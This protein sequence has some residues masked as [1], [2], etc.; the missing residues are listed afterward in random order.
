VSELRAARRRLHRKTLVIGALLAGSY[1]SLVISDFGLLLRVAAAAVLVIALVAV[2][3]SVMHDANHGAYSNHRWVNRVM[4]YTSDLLGASSWLWR[5]QHNNLHHGNTNVVGF[6][7][8]VELAPFARLAP[9]QPW[10]RWFRW[11][12]IYIWPLYGFL[13]MKNLLIADTFA[14]IQRKM[15]DQPLRRPVRAHV[16]A[17]VVLGKAAHLSW[18]VV[19]PLLFNPWWKVLVFYLACSWCVGF[20]LALIFQLAHC[21]D[22]ADVADPEAAR[23]GDDFAM[24]QL[25]TTVDISSPMPVFGHLF[26]WVV[27]GLDHQIEHHLAPRLPHTVYPKV[28][29][30][31]RAACEEQGISYRVHRGI[32]AALCS[33]VRWLRA[34]GRPAAVAA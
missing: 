12:H 16:I 34:M 8:D 6:D 33:H 24:H 28:A 10:H 18:A 1:Y 2:G 14:L 29:A 13:A 19:V 7:A 5:I 23:R 30:R 31:F 17:R 25:R 9:S 27:G 11:Q 21:V 22:L 4:S 26:R 32:G 3:T 15:G 20:A